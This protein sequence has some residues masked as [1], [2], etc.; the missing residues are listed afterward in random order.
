MWRDETYKGFEIH[1]LPVLK[2]NPSPGQQVPY[3]YTGY[4]NRP[5]AVIKVEASVRRFTHSSADFPDEATAAQTAF[6]EGRSI[7][8]RTHPDLTTDGL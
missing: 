1:V 8:D 6:E 3:S 4:V 2:H 5:G 7:I